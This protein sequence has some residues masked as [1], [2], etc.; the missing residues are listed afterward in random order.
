MPAL[1]AIGEVRS[2]AFSRDGVHLAAGSFTG[3]IQLWE[4]ANVAA[5]RFLANHKSS[6]NSLQFS[7]DGTT[8]ASAGSDRKVLLW[9]YAENGQTPI[10]LLG[11][12]SWVWA[13]AI[14]P[15]GRTVFSGGADRELR[16]WAAYTSDLADLICPSVNRNLTTEEWQRYL[17]GDIP[18]EELC[19]DLPVGEETDSLE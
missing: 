14:S 15:D 11:H 5:P 16:R 17:S 6:V 7:S 19:P 1:S 18:Y 4:L 9:S 10:A 2:L 13:V 3:L 8:L 12:G